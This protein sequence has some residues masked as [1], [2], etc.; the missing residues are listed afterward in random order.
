MSL[1]IIRCSIELNTLL[2]TGSVSSPAHPFSDNLQYFNA[3]RRKYLMIEECSYLSL[4][5]SDVM[6]NNEK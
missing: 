4:S 5:F 2:Q 6:A 1:I 3:A